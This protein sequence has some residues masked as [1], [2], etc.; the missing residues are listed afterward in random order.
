MENELVM[1]SDWSINRFATLLA[2]FSLSRWV[3]SADVTAGGLQP[4]AAGWRSW[5]SYCNKDSKYS[6]RQ[7]NRCLCFRWR[8][9]GHTSLYNMYKPS[10]E[11][12][13]K[14]IFSKSS[15]GTLVI[16]LP[17]SIS[18]LCYI[19]CLLASLFFYCLYKYS[20]QEW[21]LCSVTLTL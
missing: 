12:E 16:F 17:S 13:G 6:D 18:H 14:T 19:T 5:F 15:K 4:G 10:K 3:G 1:F 8:H 9:R 7:N 2:C 20:T 11:M 21:F